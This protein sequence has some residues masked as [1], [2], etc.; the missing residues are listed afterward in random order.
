MKPTEK[1]KFILSRTKD[2]HSEVFYT[3]KEAYERVSEIL[4]KERYVS[5][6]TR[7]II[8]DEDTLKLDYGAYN[9]FFYIKTE[10]EE[11]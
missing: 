5:Y 1:R 8:V 3:M 7:V 6:Y 4:K 10:Y 9:D 11:I 2:T